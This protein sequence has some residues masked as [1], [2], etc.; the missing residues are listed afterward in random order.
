MSDTTPALDEAGALA[1]LVPP[2]EAV[3]RVEAGALLVGVRSA[4]G[5]AGAG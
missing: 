5:W 2:A 3:K 4:A 1:P